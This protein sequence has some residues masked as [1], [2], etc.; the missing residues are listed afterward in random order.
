MHV[1]LDGFISGPDGEMDWIKVDDQLF[2]Y[3]HQ[4][5]R[6]C[7]AALYGRKTFEMMEGYWPTAAD[8]PDASTHDREH[9][10]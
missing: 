3:G 4:R 5:I 2:E 10:A 8:Q 7:D 1:S 6:D 9:S